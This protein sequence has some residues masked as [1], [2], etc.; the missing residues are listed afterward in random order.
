MFSTVYENTANNV[1][2]TAE[3]FLHTFINRDPNGSLRTDTT[4]TAEQIVGRMKEINPESGQNTTMCTYIYNSGSYNVTIAPGTGVQLYG[5]SLINPGQTVLFLVK[6]LSDTPLSEQ[7]EIY[8]N[9][10]FYTYM[11]VSA[12]LNGTYYNPIDS[13]TLWSNKSP[14]VFQQNFIYYM[15][16]SYTLPAD[17]TDTSATNRL[18]VLTQMSSGFFQSDGDKLRFSINWKDYANGR[19]RVQFTNANTYVGVRNVISFGSLVINT[20]AIPNFSIIWAGYNNSDTRV[21]LYSTN[22]VQNTRDLLN[23]SK[24]N[25]NEPVIFEIVRLNNAQLTVKWYN[26]Q[27]I[28]IAGQLDL[29]CNLPTSMFNKPNVTVA[30]GET[31]NDGIFVNDITYCNVD[32]VSDSQVN[33]KVQYIPI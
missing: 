16:G 19:L 32:E 5:T 4:P 12:I 27:M 9:Q 6:I 1:T 29:T 26:Y 25:D 13:T 23:I 11:D 7:V 31:N 3:N 17:N 2:Y 30:N 28:P 20:D 24:I 21:D 14:I 22:M 18:G 15:K 10:L 33:V 8:R